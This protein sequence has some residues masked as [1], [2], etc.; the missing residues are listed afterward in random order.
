MERCGLD[1]VVSVEIG[2]IVNIGYFLQVE[3]TR[4]DDEL[5]GL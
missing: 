5:Y 4:F 2:G 1:K 3:P